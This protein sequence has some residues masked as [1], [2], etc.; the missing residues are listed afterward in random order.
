MLEQAV[1]TSI[2]T[3]VLKGLLLASLCVCCAATHVTLRTK[4]RELSLLVGARGLEE[5]STVYRYEIQ[6]SRYTEIVIETDTSLPEQGDAPWNN[7]TRR[8]SSPLCWLCR[9]F[10]GKTGQI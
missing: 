2:I 7:A 9:L 4:A 8:V 6:E 1:L 10:Q 3:T 5:M